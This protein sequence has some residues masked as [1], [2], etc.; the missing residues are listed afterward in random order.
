MEFDHLF[1]VQIGYMGSII[2]PIAWNEVC[3]LWKVIHH[4]KDGVLAEG[5][6]SWPFDKLHIS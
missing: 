4:H 3:H 2:G 1:E 6:D 5:R